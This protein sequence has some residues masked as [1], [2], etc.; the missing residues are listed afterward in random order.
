MTGALITGT[1]P[2]N[3]DPRFCE[4]LSPHQHTPRPA[5]VTLSQHTVATVHEL[6]IL[7]EEF[8]R[9]ASPIVHA[10]LRAYLDT[11]VP[12][13]D[14]GWFIDMLGFNATDLARHLPT[15]APAP[16][17]VWTCH[18]GAEIREADSSERRNTWSF[19]QGR[20]SAD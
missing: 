10:E 11:Q 18:T 8:L 4:D 9:T 12:P 15:P 5:R 7:A 2:G 13:A 6:L 14:P 17:E 19:V 1:G 16:R 3:P 20:W